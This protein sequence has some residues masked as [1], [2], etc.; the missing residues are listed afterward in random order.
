MDGKISLMD[1]NR[2][3]RHLA[4][5]SVEI[6]LDNADYDANGKVNL[7]DVSK[8]IKLLAGK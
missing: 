3:I 5:W 1:V 2:I 6:N 4:S 8:L 7:V